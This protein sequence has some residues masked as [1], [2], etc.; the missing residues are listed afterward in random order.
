MV[1]P[2][3]NAP[4]PTTQTTLWVCPRFSRASTNPTAAETPV[5]AC[6]ALKVSYSLS[7]RLQNPLNPPNR[8][9][10]WNC[11]WRPVN[12]LWAYDWLPVSQTIRSLGVSS[13]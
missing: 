5:P 3:V 9:R 2:E 12:S 7:S 8:R 13:R 1:R 4:S 11:S 10:V 6:P